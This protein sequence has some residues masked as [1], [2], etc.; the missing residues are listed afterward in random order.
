MLNYDFHNHVAVNL[1][2][3]N[4]QLKYEAVNLLDIDFYKIRERVGKP[5]FYAPGQTG[6]KFFLLHF[7]CRSHCI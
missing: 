7:I 4:R 6:R 2:R 5:I 1:H 3:R